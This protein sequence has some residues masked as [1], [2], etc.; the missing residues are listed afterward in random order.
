MDGIVLWSCVPPAWT[1]GFE[2]GWPGGTGLFIVTSLKSDPWKGD[3]TCIER[4][5]SRVCPGSV[6]PAF[7][8]S[9]CVIGGLSPGGL[10][11]VYTAHHPW[12]A[13]W[14]EG[15]GPGLPSGQAGPQVGSQQLWAPT[16]KAASPPREADSPSTHLQPDSRSHSRL[17]QMSPAFFRPT[18]TLIPSVIISTGSL[19][20]AEWGICN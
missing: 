18:V 9:W 13:M 14:A 15:P 20:R 11:R 1:Q 5:L 17:S 16:V 2:R 8:S 19:G 10:P 4:G 12:A 6:Q 3:G 7:P